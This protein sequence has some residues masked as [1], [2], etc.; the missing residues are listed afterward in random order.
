MNKKMIGISGS[1]VTNSNTDR[2]IQHVLASSGMDSEFIK[3]STI[4][5]GPCRACK[6]CAGDN[7]C[8]VN[9]DFPEL[10]KKILESHALVIGGYTPYGMLDAYTKALLE[11]FWSMRHNKS[12]LEDK[13]TVTIL[14]SLHTNL[15]ELVHQQI[16]RE[17]MMEKTKHIAQL[18]ID[19]NLP[20]LTCGYGDGCMNG[21]GIEY[22]YGKGAKAS[23][24]HCVAIET[25]PI[26]QE[27]SK[28]G[29]LIGDYLHGI[30]VEMPSV[31]SDLFA[32]P[33]RKANRNNA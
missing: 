4:N 32:T 10:S 21:G 33:A 13:I 5:V 20:C 16:A 9:D 28:I 30:D 3:L 22:K 31:H 17:M 7:I 25:Q 18:T 24:D 6:C 19:G 2:L 11:R 1:P 29:Q 8:K 15:S 12:L 27:A 23:A 26:W 14:S